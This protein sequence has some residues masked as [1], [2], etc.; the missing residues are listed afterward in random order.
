[1]DPEGSARKYLVKPACA[2]GIVAAGAAMWRP[3]AQVAVPGV[4]AV[5]L[6]VVAAGATFVASEVCS[7]INDYLFP[8]IPV[9]N[10]FEAPVHTALNV[11]AMAAVTAAAENYYSPGLVGDLGLTE[12]GAFAAIAEMGSTY[13]SDQWI[14]P[15]Y[16]KW[17]SHH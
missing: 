16:N 4:G 9:I 1:M 3:G 11:G 5:P 8:H 12:I 17:T 14:I 15:T 10:A 2:A 13:L 6:P 7:L